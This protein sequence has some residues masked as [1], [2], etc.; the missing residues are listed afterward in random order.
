MQ[1]VY[2]LPISMAVMKQVDA[3][4]IELVYNINEGR[5]FRMGR[6]IV[7]GNSRIQDKVILREMRGNLVVSRGP[8]E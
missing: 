8:N 1:S 6:V 5:Q 3:G 4:K 2:K 7:K